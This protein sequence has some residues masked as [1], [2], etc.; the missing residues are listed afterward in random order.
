MFAPKNRSA[1]ADICHNHGGVAEMEA[2]PTK[3]ALVILVRNQPMGRL[4]RTKHAAL[5]LPKQQAASISAA[6]KLAV[7]AKLAPQGSSASPRLGSPCTTSRPEINEIIERAIEQMRRSAMRQSA[8]HDAQTSR[9]L[10][11]PSLK[12]LL[13]FLP[14]QAVLRAA[15]VA[16]DDREFHALGELFD[17]AF[18][19]IGE[20]P[21]HQQIALVID[22]LRRHRRQAV[23]RGTGS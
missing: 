18:R 15:Q 11:F 2:E 14:L 9:G 1:T 8:R 16:R 19:R 20:R 5:R 12:H 6:N 17:I 21:Q 10:F 7:I 13:D 3:N 4:F 23:R 22:Q